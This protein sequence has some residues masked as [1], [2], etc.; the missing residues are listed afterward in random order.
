MI[1]VLRALLREESGDLEGQPVWM[2]A[3]YLREH[4]LVVSCGETACAIQAEFPD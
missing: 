4:R 1:A 2:L 3:R